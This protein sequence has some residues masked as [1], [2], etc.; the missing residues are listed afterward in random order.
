M[1]HVTYGQ[2]VDIRDSFGSSCI[3]RIC[4]ELVDECISWLII[5]FV[6]VAAAYPARS[7]IDGGDSFEG[8][9][10]GLARN[11]RSGALALGSVDHPLDVSGPGIDSFNRSVSKCDLKAYRK[12][13]GLGNVLGQ[14]LTVV[15]SEPSPPTEARSLVA[16]DPPSL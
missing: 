7:V 14:L 2:V 4:D 13:T 11:D 8:V 3:F 12:Y 5:C 6:R 16:G 1:V 15:V 9:V 10:W